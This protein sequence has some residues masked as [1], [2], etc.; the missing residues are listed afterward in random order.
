MIGVY[1]IIVYGLLH[2]VQAILPN[3]Y[4]DLNTCKVAL[5]QMKFNFPDWGE[6]QLAPSPASC[7]WQDHSDVCDKLGLPTAEKRIAP[8]G[9]YI[10][11]RQ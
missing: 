11:G 6:C 5:V 7:S 9:N 4:P 3:H 10:R 1:I 2:D 8:E